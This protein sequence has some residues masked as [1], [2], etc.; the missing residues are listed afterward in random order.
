MRFNPADH[1]LKI[2]VTRQPGQTYSG[3]SQDLVVNT[4]KVFGVKQPQHGLMTGQ[5]QQCCTVVVDG[6]TQRF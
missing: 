1:A 5:L 6:F 2:L 3:F 4:D